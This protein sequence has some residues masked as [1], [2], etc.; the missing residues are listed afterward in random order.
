MADIPL[1]VANDAIPC[2]SLAKQVSNVE[3]V[4]FLVRV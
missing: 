2:S 4:G 3:R 1:D